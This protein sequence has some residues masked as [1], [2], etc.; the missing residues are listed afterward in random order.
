M[1][2]LLLIYEF[3]KTRTKSGLIVPLIVSGLVFYFSDTCLFYKNGSN[4]QENILKAAGILLGFTISIFAIF[5]GR[6]SGSIEE[7]K[8]HKTKYKLYDKKISLYTTI[9]IALGYITLIESILLIVSVL[10]PIFFEIFSLMGR[11]LFSVCIFLLLHIVI[12][13]LRVI[14]EFYFIITKKR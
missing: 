6:N 3:F 13:L 12:A 10:S 14:L 8:E 5:I 9:V 4:I 11:I 7:S 2:Y 1:E